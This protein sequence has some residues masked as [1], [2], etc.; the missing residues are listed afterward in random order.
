MRQV[1]DADTHLSEPA[2]MWA[3][4]ADPADRGLALTLET[5]ALGHTWL[6]HGGRTIHLV[7]VHHPGDVDAMARYR[8]RVRDGL[9]AEAAYEDVLPRAH[10]D[11]AVRRDQL[12]AWGVGRSVVFP[13][14][15]L[16]WE[17]ELEHDLRA[18]TVNM[19][20]WNRWAAAVAAEGRGHLV[21]VAHV[22]LRDLEWLDDELAALERNGLRLAMVAPAL[23]DGK[24]LSHPDLDRAWAAFVNHGV[25]PVFHVSAFPHPFADG[26]Y[27]GDPDVVN[28]VLSSVFLSTAPALA[29]AD[30]AV[31]GT[32][33]RHPDLRIGVMELSAVWV[34]QFLLVLDG[35]F[36]FHAR[37]NGRPLTELERRPSEYVREHVRIAAFGYERPDVLIRQA[38]DL[39][40]FCSDW[41]HAEGVVRP[42]EDYTGACGLAPGDGEAAEL[43]FGGNVEWLLRER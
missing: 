2:G 20:A 27:D 39:F 17:R 40:M 1:L 11:P 37:F 21:P 19:R 41:P 9:P 36:D 32:F 42:V 4:H 31:N 8:Q 22:S 6:R 29:L 12:A 33:A 38:G 15:G 13:N 3:G 43:L 23:V 10:W 25:T 16:L 35:G 24:R 7:E 34:P 14:F 30:L 5:D 26:W 28:P 18:Q